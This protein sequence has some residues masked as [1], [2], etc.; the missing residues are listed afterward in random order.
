MV[1]PQQYGPLCHEHGIRGYGNPVYGVVIVGIAPGQ[2]EI[3]RTKRPFTGASGKLLDAL[4]A[5]AGWHRDK[6]YTTNTICWCN[7]SPTT[8]QIQECGPRFKREL[9][10][11]HPRLIITA[12]A[13]AYQTITGHKRPKGSRG[14]VLWNDYWQC[15]VLDTHHPSYALQA[16]SMDAVQD[17]LRDL[18]KIGRVLTWPQDSLVA[19]IKYQT[20]TSL[21]EARDILSRLPTDRPVTLDIETSNSDP[22]NI[23]AYTDQLVSFAIAY[24]NVP[25]TANNETCYVF[26]GSIFPVCVRDGTHA[27]GACMQTCGLPRQVLN[28]PL[29][30]RWTFQ[31]GQYDVHGLYVYF[32]AR[33]PFRDDTMLMSVC[34]DE[35]PGYHGLKANAREW[36]GAGWYEEK[37]KPFYKGKMHL[38]DPVTI[39]EYNAKDA[40]YTLRLI[41]VFR[42]KMQAEDTEQVYK[43]IL[44]PAINTFIDMQIRG[45]NIDHRALEALAYESWFPRYLETE[46]ALRKQA[47][48]IGWPNENINLHSNPQL[49]KLLYKILSIPV[50]KH[51][52]KGNP[53]VDKETLDQIN[54]PFASDLRALR[55]L[56]KMIDYVRA[57][58]KHTKYDGLLHPSAFVSTTR[59]RR[60]SYTD[61]A[62]QTIPKDYTVGADYA[63]LR[64]VIIPHNSTTHELI[65]AD[66]N[67]IEVWLA[68]AFSKDPALLEHLQTGDVHSATAEGAFNTKRE[69]WSELEWAEKRQ[70]A[71]KI[72][73]GIQYGEGAK[74]LATPPPI[75]I[76]CSVAEASTFISQYKRTYPVY[77]KW[78][79]DIQHEALTK[80]YLRAPDGSV[81]RFPVIMDHRELRQAIN[82]PIQC[83]ASMYNLTSMIELAPLLREF[84][85]Y[86]LLNIHD[87]LVVESDRRYQCEVIALMKR[88]MEKPRFEGFPSV[89]VDV[90]VGDNLGKMVKWVWHSEID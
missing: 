43:N 84:N 59:T 78:M 86:L 68:W 3:T 42:P 6:I 12:G 20:I 87:C 38:L 28:W 82:F 72:R 56:V 23:D 49:A 60:T 27:R 53:S 71:K 48:E 4:L 75:G 88:V 35:R 7:N 54:H 58:L 39:N 47:H 37:V 45:I 17:I 33:L 29:D 67:Q 34:I 26:P 13:I 85:S 74:K 18:S 31:A 19:S 30:V 83:T 25:R 52:V 90:K 2:D 63:R 61:P 5:G 10:E 73:F 89:K 1:A 9:R 70:N 40:V 44:V 79:R 62:M 77:D 80:G 81:M 69:L 65:E 11:I 50:I 57:I 41:D 55:M 32:G 22:E 66:Y 24:N 76:G 51:T 64:E 21:E 36:L 15:Y 16:Q 14:S 46:E 8:E